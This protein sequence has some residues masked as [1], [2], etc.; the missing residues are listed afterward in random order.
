[1]KVLATIA[2]GEADW[3]DILFLVAFLLFV[4]GAVYDAM[5]HVYSGVVMFAGLAC[6]A[7]AWLLL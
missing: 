1:M 5:K 4:A 6:V 2:E 7:L 3:A